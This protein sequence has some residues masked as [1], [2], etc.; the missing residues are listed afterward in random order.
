MTGRCDTHCH[1]YLEEFSDDLPEVLKRAKEAGIGKILVPG[2]DVDTSVQALQLSREH[3]GWVYAAVGIHPNYANQVGLAQIEAVEALLKANTANIKAIGEIGLD[4]YRTWASHEDQV[5][6]FQHM[7]DLAAKYE[8]P[9]CIHIREAEQDV[10]EILAKWAESLERNKNSLRLRPGVLH[11]YSGHPEI[12]Q[13]AL[14][15]HF[16]LGIS[17]TITFKNAQ[18]LRDQVIKAGIEH[19]ITETDSPYLAPYPNRGKRN[20]PAF[21]QYVVEEIANTLGIGLDTAIQ[22]TYKNAQELFDWN[23]K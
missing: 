8:L 4:Y 15:H 19:L 16:L 3:P 5:F 9:V 7:L 12:A 22:I 23:G 6:I 17:G 18:G 13:F 21:V 11:S 20:E 14:Q 1:L 10:L 2:I